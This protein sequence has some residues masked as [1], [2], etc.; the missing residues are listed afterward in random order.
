MS[1]TP[2]V[3][4]FT[5]KDRIVRQLRENGPQSYSR[6][7]LSTLLPEPVLRTCLSLLQQEKKVQI[8]GSDQGED[9]VYLPARGLFSGSLG[10][11]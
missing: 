5:A 2:Y 9:T 4:L 3:D 7:L 6:L 10:L 11:R 8:G 1:E